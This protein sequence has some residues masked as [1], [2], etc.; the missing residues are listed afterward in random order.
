MSYKAK[1]GVNTIW[2]K[3]RW[4]CDL[5][6]SEEDAKSYMPQSNKSINVTCPLCGRVKKIKI[7]NIYIIINQLVV[8]VGMDIAMV[9]N[10][11]IQF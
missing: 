9:I 5:G 7:S 3:A 8:Y 10:I 1:L 11:L 2:D 6:V 4:M